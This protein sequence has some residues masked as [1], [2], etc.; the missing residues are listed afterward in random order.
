MKRA[1]R[2]CKKCNALT[3]WV[4]CENCG[5]E[6]TKLRV[7]VKTTRLPVDIVGYDNCFN[8]ER[9]AFVRFSDATVV[10][11]MSKDLLVPDSV[12]PERTL[13]YLFSTKTVT[14]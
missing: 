5:G 2:I 4:R 14:A 11:S 9:T 13:S 12:N 7:L 3:T 6:T 10:S 8:A 1:T